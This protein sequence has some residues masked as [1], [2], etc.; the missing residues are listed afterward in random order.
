[1]NKPLVSIIIPTYNRCHLIGETLDSILAQTYSN[2]ECLVID[3]G[4]TDDTDKI[5][6]S[7]REKDS[8]FQYHHR[9][10]NR[11]KGANACRN[12]GFEISKGEY[13]N[14]FDSDDLMHPEKI[15][16]QILNLIES[17]INYSV[18]QSYVFTNDITN[19]LGLRHKKIAS[20]NAL[21]DFILLKMVIMTPS[22]LFKK[23]FL[24]SLEYLF[25]ESLLA[26]QEWEFYVRMLHKDS[27]YHVIEEPLIYLR[28][29]KQS[30]T[31]S[32]TNHR[33]ITWNYFLARL[34]IYNNQTIN[35]NNEVSLYLQDFLL[36]YF[37]KMV[38]NYYFKESVVAYRVFVISNQRL[39]IA[40]KIAGFIS[41]FSYFLFRRGNLF[42]KL[43]KF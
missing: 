12:Y 4:S 21:V 35:F 34:K 13:I 1:M 43:L 39:S 32:D 18:C 15:E 38:R 22:S 9:P 8:R 11:A 6:A 5:L 26:A 31:Y 25:D 42:L 33:L 24:L 2:W 19:I 29:H 17:D 20:S 10:K 16:I 27:N 37:K 41:I 36:K 30:I 14:W 40:S 7:Y 28:K 3:D 23:S